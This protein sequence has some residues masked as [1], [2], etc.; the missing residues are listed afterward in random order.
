MNFDNDNND[1]QNKFSVPPTVNDNKPINFLPSEEEYKEIARALPQENENK[2]PVNLMA[3]NSTDLYQTSPR[4]YAVD[5]PKSNVPV[6][7]VLSLILVLVLGY[8]VYVYYNTASRKMICE[9]AQ[10]DIIIYYNKKSVVGYKSSTITYDIYE[11]RQYADEI[12]ITQY[13]EEFSTWFKENTQ[14]VCKK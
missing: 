9:S 10:G 14:G 7:I 12:G 13:L 2:P 5:K 4:V 6:I 3:N 1:Q 11:Q 8:I